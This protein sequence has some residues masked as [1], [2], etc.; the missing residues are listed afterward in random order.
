M[1]SAIVGFALHFVITDVCLLGFIS[2]KNPFTYLKHI[3][4][5]QT[6]AFASASSAATL[7]VTL[8]CVRGSGVVPDAITSFV[9]PL[10]ATV[11]MDGSAI[12]IPCCCIW[13]AVLNG[14]EP[15]VGQYILLIILA[16]IGSAGAA[17]VPSASIVLMI[18]AYNTVFNTT[19]TPLGLSFIMAVDWFVDR[20][21]TVLN[22]TGDSV[23]SNF[24]ASTTPLEEVQT[25]DDAQP[26]AEFV[27]ELE[28]DDMNKGVAAASSED[29][30]DPNYA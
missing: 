10:G 5:A 2:K 29:E 8:K 19:G 21:R 11:N 12:Y 20:L 27:K 16:T 1:A 9:V 15:N 14:I 18:T 13:L 17:P 4:P 26:D 3:I 6:T 7:P 23:V 30:A 25:L 24:V 22:V 28:V